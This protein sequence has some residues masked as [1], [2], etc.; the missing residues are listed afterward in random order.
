MAAPDR[1]PA[2]RW[3]EPRAEMAGNRFES[4]LVRPQENGLTQHDWPRRG[5]SEGRTSE[6]TAPEEYRGTGVR[7][8][9]TIP[10]SRAPPPAPPSAGAMVGTAWSVTSTRNA[11]SAVPCPLIRNGEELALANQDTEPSR[12]GT[13]APAAAK[14]R[15]LET[16]IRRLQRGHSASSGGPARDGDGNCANRALGLDQAPFSPQRLVR[17]LEPFS[18]GRSL[19]GHGSLSNRGPVLHGRIPQRPATG[20]TERRNTGVQRRTAPVGRLTWSLRF[21]A[22][23]DRVTIRQRLREPPLC[24]SPPA[25]AAIRVIAARKPTFE[26]PA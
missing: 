5:A 26:G 16:G 2:W 9:Q 11:R 10:L 15:W 25:G 13:T 3:N 21:A 4:Q 6:P 14:V 17:S 1:H 8:Q 24:R 7:S 22:T 20:T 12:W 23:P 18:I 19:L